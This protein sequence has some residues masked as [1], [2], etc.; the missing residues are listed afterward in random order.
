MIDTIIICAAGLGLAA[1]TIAGWAK[2]AQLGERVEELEKI[3]H[4]LEIT[5]SDVRHS[6]T[7]QRARWDSLWEEMMNTCEDL[8]EKLKEA[9]RRGLK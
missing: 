3:A 2:A 5:V 7:E 1:I 9:E 4:R 6:A 8:R